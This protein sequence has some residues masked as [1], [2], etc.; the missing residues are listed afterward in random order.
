[1]TAHLKVVC[2]TS[3]GVGSELKW[4]IKI[5]NQT[6]TVPSTS[7]APPLLTE[8]VGVGFD[9]SEGINT[10]GGQYIELIGENFGPHISFVERISFGPTGGEC[11]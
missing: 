6:N 3:P 8:V 2:E 5:D 7:Y 4:V 9:I 1:M 10:R 11:M